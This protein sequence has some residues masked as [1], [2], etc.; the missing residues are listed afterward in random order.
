[1]CPVERENLTNIREDVLCG[2]ALVMGFLN[3]IRIFFAP[4]K[5]YFIFMP[6]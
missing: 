3:L 1:L 2:S 5:V 4:L 6:K